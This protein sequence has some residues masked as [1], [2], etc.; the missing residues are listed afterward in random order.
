MSSTFK[1]NSKLV[2]TRDWYNFVGLLA[3]AV[4]GIHMGG[5]AAT[6]KLL[7]M[8]RI[9]TATRVLDVGCGAGQT[10]CLIAQRYGAQVEGIDISDVMVAKAQQRADRLGVADK[11]AFRVASAYDLPFE[12]NSF[13]VI[14]MES[15]LVPLPGVKIEALEEMSRVL[16]PGG[17]IGANEA[18]IDRQ[19]PPD[20]IDIFSQHPAT[21]TLFTG[22]TLRQLFEEANLENIQLVETKSVETPQLDKEIG[23]GGFLKIMFRAY[24]KLLYTLIKDA[25]IRQASRIDDQ[26]KKIDKRYTGYALIVGQ[27]SKAAHEA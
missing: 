25:R 21:Y 18:V 3:D 6:A 8:C 10:A 17:L 27:K 1:E 26:V 4:P 2:G 13:D 20:V 15:V 11:A 24:P 9:D 16:R 23:L 7:E 19:T 12:E 22:Q 5:A 14:L